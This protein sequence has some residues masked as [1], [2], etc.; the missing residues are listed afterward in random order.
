METC[1]CGQKSCSLGACQNVHSGSGAPPDCHYSEAQVDTMCPIDVPIKIDID[2][3]FVLREYPGIPNLD[4]G[5]LESTARYPD[6]QDRAEASLTDLPAE[7]LVQVMKSTAAVGTDTIIHLALTCKKFKAACKVAF[8]DDPSILRAVRQNQHIF[9]EIQVQLDKERQRQGRSICL[10]TERWTDSTGIPSIW[11]VLFYWPSTFP[12][13]PSYLCITLAIFLMMNGALKI[14]SCDQIENRTIATSLVVYGGVVGSIGVFCL[15]YVCLNYKFFLAG[16]S[17]L[18]YILL[19][20]HGGIFVCSCLVFI[21]NKSQ[22]SSLFLM[23]ASGLSLYMLMKH[24][25]S[26]FGPGV[27]RTNAVAS[28]VFS[29][30]STIYFLLDTSDK[31]K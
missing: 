20:S 16:L 3:A 22:T 5:V 28:L 4:G 8:E 26:E 30:L 18:F 25:R 23:L 31:I 29:S 11:K 6:P 15:L 12:Y 27:D 14:H 17:I 2:I 24:M 21:L 19:A 7:M 10:L 1:E 13:F 9:Q